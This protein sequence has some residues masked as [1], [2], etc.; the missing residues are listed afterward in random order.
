MCRFCRYL[1]RHRGICRIVHHYPPGTS[2][3]NPIEN[4]L[5]SEISKNWA[6]RPLVSYQTILNYISTTKTSMGLKVKAYIDTKEYKKGIKI[7]D[8]QMKQL[9]LNKHDTL[10]RWNYTFS[11]P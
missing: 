10:P 11:P 6:G 2:K 8:R 5:W 3:W 4:R 1:I 7:S 9:N